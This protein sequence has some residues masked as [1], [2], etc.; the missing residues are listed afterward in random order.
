L[1]TLLDVSRDGGV[2]ELVSGPTPLAEAV[3]ALG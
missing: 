3:A 2:A 1:M